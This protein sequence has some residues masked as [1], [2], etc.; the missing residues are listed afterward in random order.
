MFARRVRQTSPH[1]CH[2]RLDGRSGVPLR[3]L[4]RASMM[5]FFFFADHSP[6][7]CRASILV[8][9]VRVADPSQQLRRIAFLVGCSFMV[10][11]AALMAQ[12]IQICIMDDCMVAASVGISQLISQCPSH[13]HVRSRSQSPPPSSGR[14]FRSIARRFACL[15]PPEDKN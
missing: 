11:W 6:R 1:R 2:H 8:S 3:S 5:T 14:D 4:V 15:F 9:I 12:K 13:S 7:A 10:M